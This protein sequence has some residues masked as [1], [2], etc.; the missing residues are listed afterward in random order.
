MSV[1]KEQESPESRPV[2]PEPEVEEKHRRQAA[3]MAD[4]YRDDRSTT[5]MPGTDGMVSGTAVSDWV[6]EEG[7]SVF[8]DD[9]TPNDQTPE[10]LPPPDR[11]RGNE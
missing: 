7:N 10:H 5:V 6:D 4:S 9:R 8:D 3:K 11:T 2:V 1:D